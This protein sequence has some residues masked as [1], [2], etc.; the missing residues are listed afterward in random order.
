MPIDK[1]WCGPRCT[2]EGVSP[3][4]K[5]PVLRRYS[6]KMVKYHSALFTVSFNWDKSLVQSNRGAK[7]IVSDTIHLKPRLDSVV[8]L[9]ELDSLLIR[10]RIAATQ[11]EYVGI[12]YMLDAAE[13]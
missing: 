1:H 5:S 11:A 12:Q 6:L 10:V 2:R 9:E 8:M 7:T 4:Y 3:R 13:C